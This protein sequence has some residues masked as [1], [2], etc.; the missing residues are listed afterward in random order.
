MLL[1][2]NWEGLT[3]KQVSTMWR[4]EGVNQFDKD[5]LQTN[6]DKLVAP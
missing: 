5:F 3:E 2:Q 1:T 4:S 6:K